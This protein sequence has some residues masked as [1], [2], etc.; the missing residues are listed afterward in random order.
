VSR[1]PRI[2]VEVLITGALGFL[3]LAVPVLSDPAHV[4]YGSLIR[5]VVEGFKSYSLGLLAGVGFVAG[6]FGIAPFLL[7]GLSTV[8]AFP[9]W[10]VLDV[11]T[12]GGHN[13]FPI[14]MAFYGFYALFGVVGARLGRK[15]RS[16]QT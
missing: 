12:K 13:L 4:D 2:I 6:R 15:S 16:S 3:A 9:A 8:A 7:L 14:E 1:A 10:A 11:L 5:N